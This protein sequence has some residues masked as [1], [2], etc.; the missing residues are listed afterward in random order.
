MTVIERTL[1]RDASAAAEADLVR[2]D[3]RGLYV[4]LTSDVGPPDGKTVGKRDSIS[5][6]ER[7]SLP[8]NPFADSSF[9]TVVVAG[10]YPPDLV[11]RP[12]RYVMGS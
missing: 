3:A 4:K 11:R 7:A 2:S 5:C 9:P 10:A 12:C 6:T 8:A 1:P